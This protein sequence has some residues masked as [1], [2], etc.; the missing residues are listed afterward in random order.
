MLEYLGQYSS[1]KKV[2]ELLAADS[3]RMLKQRDAELRR[4]DKRLQEIE[5]DFDKNVDLLKRDLLNEEEFRKLN[6][7]RREER[8]RLEGRRGELAA[9]VTDQVSRQEGVSALPVRI[10]SFLKDFGSLDVRREGHAPA[11]PEDGACLQ[12]REDRA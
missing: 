5:V 2:R 11:H 6:E 7:A 3:R 8:S 10:K 4:V 9:A 1:P 12:R